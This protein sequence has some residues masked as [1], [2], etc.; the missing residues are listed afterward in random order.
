METIHLNQYELTKRWRMS[1]RT[2]ERWQDIGPAY[3]KLGMRVVYRL[4]DIEA[5]ERGG[6]HEPQ[7]LIAA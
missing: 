3:L 6:P 7:A 1:Q 5:F 4:E 2:P